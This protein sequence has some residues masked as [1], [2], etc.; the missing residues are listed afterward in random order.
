[1]ETFSALLALCEGNPPVT[2]GFSSQRLVTWSFE[3]FFDQ[4]LNKRLGKQSRH[5]GFDT[6]SRS[7]WRHCNEVTWQPLPSPGQMDGCGQIWYLNRGEKYCNSGSWIVPVSATRFTVSLGDNISRLRSIYL[8][9]RFIQGK[10]ITILQCIRKP[11]RQVIGLEKY[12]QWSP[13]VSIWIFGIWKVPRNPLRVI[14]RNWGFTV[15]YINVQ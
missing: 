14:C 9:S 10:F 6:P 4:R 15:F 13:I 2:A 12:H 3:V 11:K 5:W 1:M 8:F 7:L